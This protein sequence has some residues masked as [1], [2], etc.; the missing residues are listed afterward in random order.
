MDFIHSIIPEELDRVATRLSETIQ[1]ICPSDVLDHSLLHAVNATGL[2]DVLLS[3]QKSL[4][5]TLNYLE[6]KGY[7]N[8]ET[9]LLITASTK[10]YMS[11]R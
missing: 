10:L 11:I 3:Y 8:Q 6:Q 7:S 9:V 2:L 4:A 5:S 1:A